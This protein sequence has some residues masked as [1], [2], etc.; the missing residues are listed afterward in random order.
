MIRGKTNKFSLYK[1]TEHDKDNE[2][3]SILRNWHDSFQVNTNN[4]LQQKISDTELQL[5]T[6]SKE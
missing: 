5:E 1:K 3:T 6:R 2:I 4:T